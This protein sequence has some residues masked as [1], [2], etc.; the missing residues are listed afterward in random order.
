MNIVTKEP[1]IGINKLTK[2][3]EDTM[4]TYTLSEN[5]IRLQTLSIRSAIKAGI[6]GCFNDTHAGAKA[7]CDAKQNVKNRRIAYSV[8]MGKFYCEYS[9]AGTG[10]WD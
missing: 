4:K 1:V 2:E 6:S 9:N 3:S 7:C 8:S 5:Q 10:D